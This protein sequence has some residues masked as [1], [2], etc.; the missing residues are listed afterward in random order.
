MVNSV[1]TQAASWASSAA[2]A[3]EGVVRMGVF[4]KAIAPKPKKHFEAAS[5]VNQFG[6]G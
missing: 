6:L 2:S 1:G 5:M 4:D 3:A